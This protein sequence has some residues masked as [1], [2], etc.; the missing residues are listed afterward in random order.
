MGPILLE[1]NLCAVHLDCKLVSR[2]PRGRILRSRTISLGYSR[3][4]HGFKG[5]LQ[6]IQDVFALQPEEECLVRR[7]S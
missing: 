3:I 4:P 5:L 1:M 7:I 2:V 6:F